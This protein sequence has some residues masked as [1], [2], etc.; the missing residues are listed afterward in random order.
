[1]ITGFRH[2]VGGYQSIAGVLPD[3]TTL[4]KAIANGFPL[5][6]V[7]GRRVHMERYTTTETGDVHY[8][9][10]F[11]GNA[12]AVE[13]GIATIEQLEDGTVHAHTFALGERMRSGLAEVATASACPPSSAASARCSSCASWRGRWRATT[14]C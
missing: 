5:A 3:V 14:T 6:A 13:A 9:G 11:N 12:A 10:T 8:G 4:G 2:A 7:A 1:V